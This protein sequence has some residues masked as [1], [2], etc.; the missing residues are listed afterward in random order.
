MKASAALTR[1]LTLAAAATRLGV[2]YWTARDMV[3]R[4][5]LRALRLSRRCLRIPVDA[6]E[7]AQAARRL[8][9][10]ITR[11]GLAPSEAAARLD[12]SAWA[13]RHWIRQG[14]LPARR[15]PAGWRIAAADLAQFRRIARGA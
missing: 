14:R 3:R 6:V 12:A 13:V 7:A 2:G 10:K 9:A 11:A 1:N 15:T 5:E 4:G 8:R